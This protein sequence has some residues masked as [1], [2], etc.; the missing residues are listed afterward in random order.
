[1]A[2]QGRAWGLYCDGWAL[3]GTTSEAPVFPLWPAREYADLCATGL[4]QGYKAKDI[5]LNDLLEG[6]LPSL[7]ERGTAL[8]IFITPRDKGVTPTLGQ[9]EQDIRLELSRI[10]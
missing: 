7:R 3:A 1:M 10:E 5:D 9:F 2:D 4:W 8:G 6:L